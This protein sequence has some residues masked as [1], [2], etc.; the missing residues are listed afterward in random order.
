MMAE[1]APS[2]ES[3]KSHVHKAE[4]QNL[5]VSAHKLFPSTIGTH[6][7]PYPLIWLYSYEKIFC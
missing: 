2:L 3:L 6:K 5:I 7:E 4:E 1:A